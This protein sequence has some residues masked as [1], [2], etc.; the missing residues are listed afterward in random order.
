[1]KRLIYILALLTFVSCNPIN[2]DGPIP[3]D[4]ELPESTLYGSY[5]VDSMTING[6]DQAGT[7]DQYDAY[8]TPGK[9]F[10][11]AC[12]IDNPQSELFGG[13]FTYRNDSV[14][15]HGLSGDPEDR[16]YRRSV[17]EGVDIYSGIGID[18][19]GDTSIYYM[20]IVRQ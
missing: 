9:H 4:N 3:I 5:I 10:V 17:I 7:C 11:I 1:M 14:I 15:V 6:V 18:H 20:E 8:I 19:V 13:S 2:D 16:H 12:R